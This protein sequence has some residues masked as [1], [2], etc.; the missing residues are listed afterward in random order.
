MSNID[1]LKT[2]FEFSAAVA[3]VILFIN[4]KKL[5]AFENKIIKKWRSEK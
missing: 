5:I 4:E 1:I 2:F 3:V